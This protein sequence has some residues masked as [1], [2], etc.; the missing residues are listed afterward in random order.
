MSMFENPGYRWR[1]TYLVLFHAKNRPKTKKVEQ[2][3]HR[4]DPRYRLSNQRS[5]DNGDFESLTVVSLDDYAA[6]D[7]C[8]VEGE[9]VVEQAAEFQK[10]IKGDDLPR[11][12]REKLKQLTQYDARFDVFHFEQVADESDDE[13]DDEMLDP[14]SLLLVLSAL[15]KLTKGVAIDPQSGTILED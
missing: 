1:E 10:E 11:S 3:L 9:D 5:T 4:V 2:V 7:I 12:A 13:D 15:A 6:L 14:G 8:Y